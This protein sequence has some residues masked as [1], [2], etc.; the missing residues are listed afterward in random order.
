[1]CGRANCGGGGCPSC[2]E[3]TKELALRRWGRS[4]ARD[5]GRY[6]RT[7]STD[8]RRRGSAWARLRSRTEAGW[9]RCAGRSWMGAAGQAGGGD[10]MRGV[11]KKSEDLELPGLALKWNTI[12]LSVVHSTHIKGE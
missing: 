7:G 2:E 8:W 1:M 9:E 12:I 5:A 3:A 4:S 10:E 6:L 11:E